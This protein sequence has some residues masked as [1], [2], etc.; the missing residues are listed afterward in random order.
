MLSQHP[1]SKIETFFIALIN[2]SYISY[3]Y[4]T[5]N[6]KEKKHSDSPCVHKNSIRINRICIKWTFIETDLKL[7]CINIALTNKQI[8][9]M[10]FYIKYSKHYT[11][12]KQIKEEKKDVKILRISEKFKHCIEAQS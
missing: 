10:V 12:M 8:N 3:S 9:R 2:L 11:M 6:D 1:T 7:F 5:F 4:K